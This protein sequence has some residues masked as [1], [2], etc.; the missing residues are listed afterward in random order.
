MPVTFARIEL[1]AKADMSDHDVR[2]RGEC[3]DCRIRFEMRTPL[4]VV[5]R[6]DRDELDAP[7]PSDFR[8]LDAYAAALIGDAYMD[9]PEKRARRREVEAHERRLEER[10]RRELAR[11]GCPH[12]TTSLRVP[13]AS[14]REVGPGAGPCTGPRNGPHGLGLAP[15]ADPQEDR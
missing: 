9:G 11:A 2:Y 15:G 1:L 8:T 5:Q 14:G 10:A 13:E 4:R 6:Y 7:N 3:T 12:A